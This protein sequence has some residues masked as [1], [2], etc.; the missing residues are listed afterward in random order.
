[1]KNLIAKKL[2]AVSVNLTETANNLEELTT[3]LQQITKMQEDTKKSI[4]E[5][6]DML[7]D[8]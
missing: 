5:I 8:I 1:M 7:E 2:I 4:R 6:L 3:T